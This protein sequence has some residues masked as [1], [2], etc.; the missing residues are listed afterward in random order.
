MDDLLAASHGRSSIRGEAR[1]TSDQA[2]LIIDVQEGMFMQVEQPYRA[3]QL[4]ANLQHVLQEARSRSVPVVYVRH[5][6]SR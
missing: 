4:I 6:P 2:V 3:D 5:R 1:M